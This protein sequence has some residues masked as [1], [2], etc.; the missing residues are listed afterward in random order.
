[1][2]ANQRSMSKIIQ[3]LYCSKSIEQKKKGLAV[4]KFLIIKSPQ[5]IIPSRTRR[6]S[7]NL[8]QIAIANVLDRY[9]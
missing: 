9:G 5:K 4:W 3:C 2:V 7:R 1:M 6:T 8:L